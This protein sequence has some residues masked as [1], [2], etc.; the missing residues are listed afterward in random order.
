[1]VIILFALYSCIYLT[2][3]LYYCTTGGIQVGNDADGKAGGIIFIYDDKEPEEEPEEDPEEG[4][5][6]VNSGSSDEL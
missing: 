6:A 4:A 3:Q 2:L 1:M 5:R